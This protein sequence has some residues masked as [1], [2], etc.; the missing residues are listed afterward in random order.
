[1]I[2]G[3]VVVFL[4]ALIAGLD[5]NIRFIVEVTTDFE[6]V[7]NAQIVFF[8]GALI[9]LFAGYL[10]DK[11]K[12]SKHVIYACL[13]AICAVFSLLFIVDAEIIAYTYVFSSMIPIYTLW[14]VCIVLPVRHAKSHPQYAGSGYAMLYLG[15]IP[16]S[17][18]FL[19]SPEEG[20]YRI[21][22]AMV[23][24]VTVAALVLSYYLFSAYE[25]QRYL[26][27]LNSQKAELSIL[28]NKTSAEEDKNGLKPDFDKIISG[29]GLTPRES[30]L[31]PLVISPL[32]AKEI[33][34]KENM[35]VGNAKY[36]IGNI[37]SKTSCRTRREL[38]MLIDAG[39]M[40]INDDTTNT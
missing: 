2:T 26:I 14:V 4:Y 10:I 25:K 19:V 23:L 34:N 8:F 40:H 32:T 3:I 7:F 11:I 30:E 22:I 29:F 9:Y 13:I 6:G 17:V 28:S 39:Q 36:H 5:D 31:F 37:L 24:V 21:A 18:M 1:M 33:A 38:Q 16:T 12:S 27:Q 20:T 35:S 15:M